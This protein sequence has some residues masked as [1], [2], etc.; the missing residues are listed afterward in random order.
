MSPVPLQNVLIVV[1]AMSGALVVLTGILWAAG[2]S[3]SRS[4]PAVT[5][6]GAL[7]CL[8]VISSLTSGDG[9]L[10]VV[11]SAVIFGPPALAWGVIWRLGDAV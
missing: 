3:P 2:G 9:W 10:A 7:A 4:W 5:A 11:P 8:I 1:T 6:A